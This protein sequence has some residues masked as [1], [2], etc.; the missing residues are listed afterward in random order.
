[1]RAVKNRI[2]DED[3]YQLKVDCNGFEFWVQINKKDLYGEPM[4]GR[5]FKGVVWMQGTVHYLD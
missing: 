1:M 2:T 3:I 5:R 4:P